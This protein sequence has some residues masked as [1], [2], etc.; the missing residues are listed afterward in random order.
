M[1]VRK[2][3][4]V[5]YFIGV[6]LLV[7]G[8]VSYAA[9][10]ERP[11]EE[12]I[13]ILLPSSAGKVLFNMKKHTAEDGYGYECTDCHH[14]IEDPEETPEACKECHLKNK[15]DSEAEINTEEAFHTECINCHEEDG[16]APVECDQCHYMGG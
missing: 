5:A 13:R 7:I 16:T 12:P 3:R 2:E 14:D 4:I 10:P 15:E 6:I 9:F 1:E 11:P 8:I